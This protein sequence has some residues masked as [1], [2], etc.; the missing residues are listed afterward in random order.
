M[1]R[2]NKAGMDIARASHQVDYI[3]RSKVARIDD[4][5]GSLTPAS[6]LT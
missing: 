4:Q 6:W 5:T 1:S 2:G 3:E